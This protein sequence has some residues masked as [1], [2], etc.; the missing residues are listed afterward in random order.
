MCPVKPSDKE[1]EHFKK[2]ESMRL[3]KL[4]ADDQERKAAQEREDRRKLHFMKCPKCGGELSTV[5]HDVVDIDRCGECGGV[6]L[7]AGEL[8]RLLEAEEGLVKKTLK[9]LSLR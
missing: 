6:W 2:T 5:K 9:F 4:A 7:D 3:K 1:E 8:E